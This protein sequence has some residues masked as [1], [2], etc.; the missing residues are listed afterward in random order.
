MVDKL[1]AFGGQPSK[2]ILGAAMPLPCSLLG[3]PVAY[4]GVRD[5]AGRRQ[6]LAAEADRQDEA[7]VG[8]QDEAVAPERFGEQDGLHVNLAGRDDLARS[9]EIPIQL[10]LGPAERFTLAFEHAAATKHAE[11]A[12]HGLALAPIE[13]TR[14]VALQR[15]RKCANEAD[16]GT[17]LARID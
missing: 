6:A 9:N 16:G 17:P 15:A 4:I 8:S 12:H 10:V 3:Q 2:S 14:C 5:G 7:V 11:M 1:Y 13:R